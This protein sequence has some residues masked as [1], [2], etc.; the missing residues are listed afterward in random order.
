MLWSANDRMKYLVCSLLHHLFSVMEAFK[1]V[2]TM[3]VAFP[4]VVCVFHALHEQ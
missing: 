1:V 4:G 3:K 2:L